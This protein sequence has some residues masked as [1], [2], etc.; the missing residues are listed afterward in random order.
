MEV[1]LITEA[2][3]NRN[4]YAQFYS[5][6]GAIVLSVRLPGSFSVLIGP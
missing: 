4:N 2:K 6:L 5:T 3:C 1:M